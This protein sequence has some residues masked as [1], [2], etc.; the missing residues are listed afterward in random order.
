MNEWPVIEEVTLAADRLGFDGVLIPDHYMFSEE[1]MGVRS[2]RNATLESW[3]ALAVLASRTERVKVGTLVSPIPLRPPGLLAKMVTTVDVLSK[4]RVVL[5][6]GAGWSD[7]EFEGYS[8]W[9][10]PKVRVDKVE[11]GVE[12]IRRL[13]TEDEVSFEGTYYKAKNAVLE[14]KPVQKPHPTLLFGGHKNRMLGLA[15]RFADITYIKTAEENLDFECELFEEKKAT[16]LHSAK[17]QKRSKEL[18]FMF[19]SFHF[20]LLYNP[21]DVKE[22]QG[23]VEAAEKVGA[24]YFL[25][26]FPAGR[27]VE[28][29]EQ[30]AKEIMPSYS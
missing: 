14:P 9:D 4:G 2:D 24:Q 20:H 1:V 25:T 17:E 23:R 30:F 21:F 16:V 7:V 5:G 27:Q 29:M 28:A 6:V 11:E 3:I 26:P 15:G 8:V 18:T 22:C 10:S 12:L 19:G 13:W